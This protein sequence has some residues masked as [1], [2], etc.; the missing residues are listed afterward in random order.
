M[1]L[2]HKNEYIMS[3]TFGSPYACSS[4]MYINIPPY[5]YRDRYIYTVYIY[6]ELSTDLYVQG[7][8]LSIPIPDA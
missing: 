4:Q 1:S 3:I 5:I 2:D 6:S 8:Y 7:N